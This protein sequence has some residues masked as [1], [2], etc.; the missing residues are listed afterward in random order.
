MDTVACSRLAPG[1]I[2]CTGKKAGAVTLTDTLTASPDGETLTLSYSIFQGD[3]EIA[4][5]TGIFE[6]RRAE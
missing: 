1:V 2:A 5:G 3:Q 4:K 6:R